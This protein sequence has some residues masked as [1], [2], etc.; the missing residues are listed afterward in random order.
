[1]FNWLQEINLDI[2]FRRETYCK[3]NFMKS[4]NNLWKGKILHSVTDSVH[5]RG[6][7]F[8]FKNNL[9]VEILNTKSCDMGHLLLVN[10]KVNEEIITLVNIYA[11]NSETDRTSFYGKVDKWITDYS[12]NVN[13]VVIA[14]DFNCCL[15]DSDRQPPTH[16]KD[17]SRKRLTELIEH[18]SLLDAKQQSNNLNNG[19]TFIDK[20]HGTKSRL[21]YIFVSQNKYTKINSKVVESF[22]KIDHKLVIAELTFNFYKRGPNYWKFNSSL[23]K[24]KEYC[25]YIIKAINECIDKYNSSLNSQQLWEMIK[26]SVKECTVNYCCKRSKKQKSEILILQNKLEELKNLT[27]S[28]N[29]Q[30]E[31]CDTQ[32]RLNELLETA[33]QGS[34]IR[35]KA[36]WCEKGDRCSKFF[37]N[38]ESK[39]QSNNTIN[40]IKTSNGNFVHTDSDIINELA[41]YYEKL[42]KSNKAN[43]DKIEQ[44]FSDTNLKVKLKD[45]EK[46]MCETPISENEFSNVVNKLK[47]NKSPGLDGLTPEFYKHFWHHL[48]TPFCNMVNESFVKKTLPEAMKIA[49]VSLL[50]KK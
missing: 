9:N 1:M 37:M 22:D 50:H 39:R 10:I 32:I 28:Q 25:Q 34:Y 18:N 29:V 13:N 48:S 6:V 23:L 12:L 3:L 43:N 15:L 14:G 40:Q 5:S 26:V 20:Q 35:S 36:E 27:D 31:I 21:D 16:L 33:T 45:T 24:D 30:N 44:Y 49:V 42:F 11:P 7:C 2:I 41:K 19:F 17:K 38:L 47:I 46:L 8:M 4:F